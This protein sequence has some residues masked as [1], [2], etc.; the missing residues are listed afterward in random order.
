MNVMVSTAFLG[1][2]ALKCEVPLVS[3][4][5]SKTILY[6]FVSTNTAIHRGIRRSNSRADRAEPPNGHYGGR[7]DGF[8]RG[9]RD[10]PDQQQHTPPRFPR[11]NRQV[12]QDVGDM[13]KFAALR[14][15]RSTTR[16]ERF[17][18]G[19]TGESQPSF[20]SQYPG[21]GSGRP[22]ELRETPDRRRRNSP[23]SE[24]FGNSSYPS[25][26]PPDS[27][28]RNR[29]TR[30]SIYG[31]SH[32]PPDNNRWPERE[33]ETDNSPRWTPNM[34]A[35]LRIR[36][37]GRFKY[38]DSQRRT[39]RLARAK[40]TPPGGHM[41]SNPPQG[42]PYT[43]PASE[44]LYGTS[45]VTAALKSSRRKL[46]KVYIYSS[47][48]RGLTAQDASIRKTALAMG[49]QVVDVKGNWIKLLDKMS[50]GR[51]HNVRSIPKNY[52]I[53]KCYTISKIKSRATFSKRLR[54]RGC[55]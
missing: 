45:V 10:Y 34:S 6:R 17:Q 23:T 8:P 40:E 32:N 41:R 14:E 29:A 24:P 16:Q 42:I 9:R 31:D 18:R 22:Y 35:P 39:V 46:Y 11:P 15:G 7:T 2:Q 50:N 43:T 12:E 38:S 49:V 25:S 3:P 51:P 20:G 13:R 44:F 19:G 1:R 4:V 33:R 26:A 54:C 28:W 21:Q 37:R 5:F 36:P 27:T 53:N 52:V 47:E 30:A 48:G 55:Q